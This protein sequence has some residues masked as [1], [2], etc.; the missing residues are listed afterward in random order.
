MLDRPNSLPDFAT[1]SLG[2]GAVVLNDKRYQNMIYIFACK[3]NA[4]GD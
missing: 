3:R 4:D 1:S 2:A